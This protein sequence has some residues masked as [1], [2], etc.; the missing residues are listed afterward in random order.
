MEIKN[1]GVLTSLARTVGTTAG[2]IVAKTTKLK[3]EVVSMGKKAAGA[4]SNEPIRTKKVTTAK[5]PAKRRAST[6]S[7][8]KKPAAKSSS[9]ATTKKT[10][11]KSAKLSAQRK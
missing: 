1:E 6:K 11:K 2:V 9:R 10:K 8:A 3:D 5:K 4:A 7:A